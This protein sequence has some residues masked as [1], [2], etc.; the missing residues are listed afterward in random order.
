MSA[1]TKEFNPSTSNSHDI[2]KIISAPLVAA[3]HAN[4]MMQREQTTFMMDVGFNENNGKYEP[5]MIEM[6]LN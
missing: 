4:S 3:S 6:V 1:K 5:I 2:E